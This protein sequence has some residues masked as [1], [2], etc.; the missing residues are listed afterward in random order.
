MVVVIAVATIANNGRPTQGQ[1]REVEITKKDR[2]NKHG[3]A[4]FAANFS[5]A[6][7][8]QTRVKWGLEGFH[9]GSRPKHRHEQLPI[10]D[11]RQEGGSRREEVARYSDAVGQHEHIVLSG[12]RIM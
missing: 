2:T 7:G 4:P 1:G 5:N 3:I 10:K 8:G 12:G 9:E 6:E 11:G